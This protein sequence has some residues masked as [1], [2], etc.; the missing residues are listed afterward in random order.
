MQKSLHDDLPLADYYSFGNGYTENLKKHSR[1]AGGA[2]AVIF[3]REFDAN[4]LRLGLNGLIPIPGKF[5]RL[6]CHNLKSGPVERI[7]RTRLPRG[8]I[9]RGGQPGI[10]EQP[11]PHGCN[12]SNL[13]F[14]DAVQGTNPVASASRV[15]DLDAIV[16]IRC[17]RHRVGRTCSSGH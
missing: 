8:E 12:Q 2:F 4:L 6:I 15:D 11:V 10:K 9:K 1:S 17:L 16:G 3:F 5:Y 14:G 13:P 7:S